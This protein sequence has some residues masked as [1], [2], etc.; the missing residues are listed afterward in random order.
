MNDDPLEHMSDDELSER[1]DQLESRL[2]LKDLQ[3]LQPQVNGQ[4]LFALGFAAG[5][6]VSNTSRSGVWRTAR[7]AVLSSL[8]SLAASILVMSQL[9]PSVIRSSSQRVEVVFD[10]TDASRPELPALPTQRG[11]G[12]VAEFSFEE[13]LPATM[14]D[15][16]TP[17]LVQS[18]EYEKSEPKIE[19]ESIRYVTQRRGLINETLLSSPTSSGQSLYSN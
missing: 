3:G 8:V 1:I 9:S 11:L 14:R 17:T 2:W 15:S 6:Q 7:T 16:S 5:Q 4:Y 10:G 13:L 12:E 18:D 19:T